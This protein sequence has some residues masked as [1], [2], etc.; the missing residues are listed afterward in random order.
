[1]NQNGESSRGGQSGSKA[2][3]TATEVVCSFSCG[4]HLGCGLC[5][6]E[7]VGMDYYMGPFTFNGAR[8]LIWRHRFFCL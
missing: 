7:S 8:S 5:G 2:E 6:A 3:I 1:M 4:I